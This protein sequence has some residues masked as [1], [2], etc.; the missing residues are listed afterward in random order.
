MPK[1]SLGGII[2]NQIETTAI[3]TT[4]V[5]ITLASI[6]DLFREEFLGPIT[7]IGDHF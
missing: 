2:T 7:V 6:A 4:G 1:G 5:T 3:F